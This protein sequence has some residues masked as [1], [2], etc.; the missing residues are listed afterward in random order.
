MEVSDQ[1]HAPGALP[2]ILIEVRNYAT[3]KEVAGLKRDGMND[4]YQF[5]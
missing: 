3:S 1:L 4:F 5:T 2:Q